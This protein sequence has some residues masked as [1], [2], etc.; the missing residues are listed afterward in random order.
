[1]N[2]GLTPSSGL[3]EGRR[4][5]RAREPS[6]HSSGSAP[7]SS[8]RSSGSAPGSSGLAAPAPSPPIDG[9]CGPDGTR[10]TLRMRE[11][12]EQAGLDRQVVHYYIREGLVP[13]GVK[14]TRNSAFYG[15][16]HVERLRLVRRLQTERF[17]PLRAIRALLAGEDGAL[18]AFTPEQTRWLR[19]LKVAAADTLARGAD[20]V[21]QVE[22]APLLAEHAVS[23]E[24]LREL[25]EVGL[26]ATLEDASGACFI[27]ADDAWLVATVGA[28]RRAGF[29]EARG[30][31]VRDLAI[32]EEAVAALFDRETRL[33]AGRITTLPPEEAATML[34][35]LL[36][37]VN[38]LLARCHEAR[39]RRLFSMLF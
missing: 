7:G 25:A 16:V 26:L 23:V 14:A 10:W 18:G 9:V 34:A 24:D 35:G 28:L 12:C 29:S 32:Y 27:A 33:L 22:A 1:L 19:A 39:V 17:L 20:Q 38:Q 4:S 13:P 6:G 5:A 37:L 15:A 36:P 8:G 21:E 11:V 3:G 31:A 30:F 2:A